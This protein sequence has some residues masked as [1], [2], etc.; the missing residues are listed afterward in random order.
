MKTQTSHHFHKKLSFNLT[1][2]NELAARTIDDVVRYS[3]VVTF[4]SVQSCDS[5]HLTKRK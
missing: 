5:Y 4:V 1:F 2:N 3:S